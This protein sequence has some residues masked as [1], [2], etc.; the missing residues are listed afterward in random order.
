M[1]AVC[2]AATSAVGSVTFLFI[3]GTLWSAAS[4]GRLGDPAVE[5][6]RGVHVAAIASFWLGMLLYLSGLFSA[7]LIS[8][9]YSGARGGKDA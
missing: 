3:S 1:S 8:I 2:C 9:E 6:P 7:S 5:A 4:L